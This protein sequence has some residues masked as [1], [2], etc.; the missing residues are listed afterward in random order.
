MKILLPEQHSPLPQQ[1]DNVR[2]S[3]E[4]VFPSEIW[5]ARFISKAPMII[6][7]RQNF[8]AVGPAQ[9]VIVLAVTG[10]DMHQACTGIHGHEISREYG[11]FSI[12]KWMLR[13]KPNQLFAN[14]KKRLFRGNKSSLLNEL[15]AKPASSKHS[16]VL[17]TQNFVFGA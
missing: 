17:I 15:F 3:I 16:L 9:P 10:C 1:V 13:P 2:I 11:R 12:E 14:T 7:R 8:Q 4:H 6:N 5:Q